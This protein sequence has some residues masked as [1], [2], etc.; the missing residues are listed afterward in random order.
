M[1]VKGACVCALVL[2]DDGSCNTGERIENQIRQ[3]ICQIVDQNGGILCPLHARLIESIMS[4][5][6]G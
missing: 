2:V 1:C 5:H 6:V 4:N 3:N